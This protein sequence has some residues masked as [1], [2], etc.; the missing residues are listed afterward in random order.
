MM[1]PVRCLVRV[2][3]CARA[4][5]AHDG[6]SEDIGDRVSGSEVAGAAADHGGRVKPSQRV[7]DRVN[8]IQ[9]A[10][11]RVKTIRRARERVDPV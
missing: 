10:S 7:S 5:I 11:E 6:T 4:G 2:C 8:P 1:M 3:V 9:R